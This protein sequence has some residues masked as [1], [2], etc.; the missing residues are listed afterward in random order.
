MLKRGKVFARPV[1]SHHL[2]YVL[3]FVQSVLSA[4]ACIRLIR[5]DNGF[6]TDDGHLAVALEEIYGTHA[7][8]A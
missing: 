2:S 5:S 7:D 6:G 3:E 1:P 4:H 8:G